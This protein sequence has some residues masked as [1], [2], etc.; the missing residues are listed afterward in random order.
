VARLCADFQI[1]P[2]INVNTLSI[3]CEAQV[4]NGCKDRESAAATPVRGG[5]A[6]PGVRILT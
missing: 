6:E 2:Y 3:Q 4:A 5:G 1:L